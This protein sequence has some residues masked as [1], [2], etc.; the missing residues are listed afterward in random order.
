MFPEIFHAVSGKSPLLLSW[1]HYRTLI[2]E[3]NPDARAWY[4]KEATAQAWSSR[5]L[6]RNVSSQYYFRMVASQKKDLVKKEMLHLTAPAQTP[7]PTEFIKNQS[8]ILS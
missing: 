6:Q 5:S 7:D 2:Q 1:T 4:E 3:L 8:H